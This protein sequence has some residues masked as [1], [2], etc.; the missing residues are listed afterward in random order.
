MK[1]KWIIFWPPSHSLPPSPILL[2]PLPSNWPLLPT[3]P[4]TAYPHTLSPPSDHSPGTVSPSEMHFL[5]LVSIIPV[6]A[7]T[8]HLKA[9]CWSVSYSNPSSLPLVGS[10]HIGTSECGIFICRSLY[11][12]PMGSDRM[13]KCFLSCL[14]SSQPA[15]P[16]HFPHCACFLMPYRPHQY[17]LRY[18]RMS[19]AHSSLWLL[20]ALLGG[21]APSLPVGLSTPR[22]LCTL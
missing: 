4:D 5:V 7:E 18:S 22:S 12:L 1:S 16:Q 19:W 11:W 8:H 13:C 10:F 6:K 3:R 9:P 15:H 21:V 17:L 14:V 20:G 2:C